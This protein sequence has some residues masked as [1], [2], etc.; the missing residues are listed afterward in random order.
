MGGIQESAL[1]SLDLIQ[2]AK[3]ADLEASVVLRNALLIADPTKSGAEMR[4]YE[5]QHLLAAKAL[6][7]LKEYAPDKRITIC[8]EITKHFEEVIAGTVDHA[9]AELNKD[10]KRQKGEFVVIVS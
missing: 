9:V 1:P 4:R 8:R 10:T 2:K 3:Y 7:S 5:G 6:E